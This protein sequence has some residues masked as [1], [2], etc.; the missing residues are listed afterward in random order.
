MPEQLTVDRPGEKAARATGR[1]GYLPLRIVFL[2]ALSFV[3]IAAD[4]LMAWIFHVH[5]TIVFATIALIVIVGGL[6]VAEVMLFRRLYALKQAIDAIAAG[7]Y[8]PASRLRRPPF[9]EISAYV[10]SIR[11]LGRDVEERERRIRRSEEH[12]RLI[13]DNARDIIY[14][15]T[16]S[17]RIQF[18]SQTV[19]H[20]LGLAVDYLIGTALQD[21]MHP[22]DVDVVAA[23]FEAI[24]PTGMTTLPPFRFRH[25]DGHY[26]WLEAT[27]TVTFD[28]R[29]G[30][31][32]VTGSCRDVTDRRNAETAL[33][34]SEA[35]YRLV[36]DNASDV[37][38]QRDLDGTLTYLSPSVED[39]L[40]YAPQELIGRKLTDLKHPDTV[41]LLEDNNAAL[42]G[43]QPTL[44]R[45]GRM[46]HKDGRYLWVEVTARLTQDKDGRVGG[47]TGSLRDITDRQRIEAALRDSTAEFL[48]FAENASDIIGR[49][50]A[51]GRFTYLS[52]SVKTIMGFEP[53]E[54]IGTHSLVPTPDSPQ[55]DALAR[56]VKSEGPVTHQAKYLNKDGQEVWLEVTINPIRDPT[57]DEVVEIAMIARDVSRRKEI[58][59]RLQ[60]AKESAERANQLKSEFV[61][62]ISHEIR[63]PMNG[64]IGMTSLLADTPLTAEQK[65]YVTAID[66]SARSLMMIINDILDFS[67]LEAEKLDL[68]CLSFRPRD[69]VEQCVRT[70]AAEAT[71]KGIVLTADVDPGC[72]TLVSGDPTRILQVLNN[73]VANGVKF[74]DSGGVSVIVR[75][76]SSDRARLTLHFVVSDTGIGIDSNVLPRIFDKFQQADGSITRRFGGTG[77]GLSIAKRLVELMGGTIG[78]DSTLG[79]GSRFWFTLDLPLA[80]GEDAAEEKRETQPDTQPAFRPGPVSA[81]VLLVEDNAVN[82]FLAESL[83]LRAG[84]AVD[85]AP[86]GLHAIDAARHTHYDLILMDAQ[87]PNMDGMQA[88]QA[89]RDLG[90]WCATVPVIAITANAM[91]G[92]RDTYLAAGM[93]DYV[94]KPIEPNHFVEVAVGWIGRK[95]GAPPVRDEAGEMESDPQ[96]EFDP[97]RLQELRAFLPTANVEGL[98]ATYLDSTGRMCQRIHALAA[99]GELPEISRCAHDLSSTSDQIGANRLAAVAQALMRACDE[100]DRRSLALLVKTLDEAVAATRA[101]LGAD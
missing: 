91:P 85:C 77:L 93:D 64:V 2:A 99:V 38:Y 69:V 101:V 8:V 73:L 62:T 94:A 42:L 76:A 71:G 6:R 35:L 65:R 43:G 14:R 20:Q 33:R 55:V 95:A 86:D 75:A 72:D 48:L 34:A 3:A 96:V 37:I 21:H 29:T 60:E 54:L 19:E 7:D 83:L 40:G 89:I 82:R 79:E 92:A 52:P 67:K 98:V 11:Q 46:R 25:K 1:G 74:T 51:D 31:N 61:A 32:R 15:A 10:D 97:A 87:M 68:D 90:G 28:T 57:S 41:G 63:T 44:N 36:V 22:E 80:V 18:V 84:F 12:S 13:A 16:M 49:L 59:A 70:V 45:I 47:I 78:V 56:A 39:I 66:E 24:P 100:G 81:R 27:A 53:T 26:R 9:G 58:E 4:R 88:T 30:R 50:D 17:G 5:A 23:A